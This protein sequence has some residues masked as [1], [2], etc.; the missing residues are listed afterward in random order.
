LNY[1]V[2]SLIDRISG[3]GEA[4]RGRRTQQYYQNQGY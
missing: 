4:E 2:T 1:L 3:Q